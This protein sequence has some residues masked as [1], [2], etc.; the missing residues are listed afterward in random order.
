MQKKDP[1]GRLFHFYAGN[2]FREFMEK[3]SSSSARSKEIMA[4]GGLQPSFLAIWL[5]TSAF[6]KDLKGDEHIF[7]D[8]SPRTLTESRALDD[9]LK[10]YRRGNPYIFSINVS[11]EISTKRLLD[12]GRADDN[13]EAITRRVSWFD[14]IVKPAIDFFRNNPDYNFVDVDG[15]QSIEKVNEEVIR[16]IRW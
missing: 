10:F 8:G 1:A 13:L 16:A 12:R 6:V 14:T 11:K 7:I 15:E 3:E 9:A 2:H 4:A 5:W